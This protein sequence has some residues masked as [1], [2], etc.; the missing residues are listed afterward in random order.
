METDRVGVTTRKMAAAAALEAARDNSVD[1]TPATSTRQ[2]KLAAAATSPDAMATPSAS[3]GRGRLLTTEVLAAANHGSLLP[4]HQEQAETDKDS[5]H[6]GAL[7][8][9]RLEAKIQQ[10]T[11][12][13]FSQF[14]DSICE[15]Q[16]QLGEQMTKLQE[17]FTAFMDQ[18]K[19]HL[20]QAGLKQ[21]S[22]ASS[23]T[24]EWVAQQRQ[25]LRLQVGL[26]KEASS[27][28]RSAVVAG[29]GVACE[30]P[31]K[32]GQPRQLVERGG[33]AAP[34]ASNAANNVEK[35]KP[36]GPANGKDTGSQAASSLSGHT[37][38][39]ALDKKINEMQTQ[40]ASVCNMVL[41][42]QAIPRETRTVAAPPLS[43]K[44]TE[45]ELDGADS[46]VSSVSQLMSW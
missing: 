26:P 8:P 9:D 1:T 12:E 27:M 35:P 43:V 6:S 25:Q 17:F 30:A 20:S 42:L 22:T 46:Q 32:R 18:Q 21:R 19:E 4:R 36:I 3:I 10:H 45:L 5:I 28:V 34:D 24:S 41:S 15:R 40:L 37:S 38:V 31:E 23:R 7:E 44:G 29:E 39:A 16:Q 33:L 14:A 11:N 2:E 13:L